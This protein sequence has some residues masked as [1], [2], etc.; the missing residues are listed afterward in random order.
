MKK[1]FLP[2][3][4][5]LFSL[6]VLPVYAEALSNAGFIAGQIWYSSET[7]TEGS[8]VNIHTA[9]WNG[10]K[11]PISVKVEFYDKNVILGTRDVTVA[12]LELKDV[13]VP[14]EITSGSHT[15]SA[16]ITSSTASGSKEQIVLNR[17]ETSNDKQFVSV[18][19][20]NDKG[21]KVAVADSALQNQINKTTAE[22]DTIVPEGVQTRVSSAFEV[23]EGFREETLVK[24][25]SVKEEAKV[26][27]DS[28][29]TEE[30]VSVE[31][32]KGNVSI[33]KATEKPITYIKLFLFTA[34]TFIFGN[35]IAFYV[36]SIVVIF[37]VLRFI[38]RKIR[39][40]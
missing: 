36:I 2:T 7:L 35:K 9:V 11:N 1:Y 6:L 4:A 20:T 23:V 19:T 10:E 8:T 17:K 21:E 13:Y 12:S 30:G 29:K 22:I 38:Y 14:W 18:T 33:D 25:S 40:K 16:K 31:I 34:L 28:L 24:V 39:N 3:L 15:I 37:L 5:I 27:L 26:E 32:T